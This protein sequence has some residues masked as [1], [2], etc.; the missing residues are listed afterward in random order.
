MTTQQRHRGYIGID[1]YM[2][3]LVG[4]ITLAVPDLKVVLSSSWRT[5]H[6]DGV[7]EVEKQVVS[8][9]DTTPAPWK[10]SF[11]GSEIQA[12]LDA[13]PRVTRYAILDDD[14][15]LLDSQLNNWFRTY[16][17]TGITEDIMQKVIDHFNEEDTTEE[18][19]EADEAHR[20]QTET[21]KAKSKEEAYEASRNK[22]SA[23]QMRQSINT[24]PQTLV[25]AKHPIGCSNG[26][27][28]PSRSQEQEHGTPLLPPEPY[29][30]DR[31]RTRSIAPE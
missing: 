14:T 23:E 8:L 22:D 25:P 12:W 27:S 16:W 15:H 29:T 4:K 30:T 20:I 13:H 21:T 11:R 2:A 3:F 18:R 31:R 17:H 6:D 5:F 9:Y 26:S 7:Q 24:N 1:P 10:G 19:D 28:A